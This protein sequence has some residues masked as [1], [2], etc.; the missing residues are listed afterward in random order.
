MAEQVR[1]PLEHYAE[2]WRR[3]ALDEHGETRQGYRWVLA[4][5]YAV[6]PKAIDKWTRQARDAGLLPPSQQ[7]RADAEAARA[8]LQDAAN[9]RMA[10]LKRRARRP[11]TVIRESKGSS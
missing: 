11:L 4:D 10:L 3:V 2:V 8:K 9:R 7:D 5:H 6:T 1:P